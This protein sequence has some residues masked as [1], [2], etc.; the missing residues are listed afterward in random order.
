MA[1]WWGRK[2]PIAVGCVFMVIGGLLGAFSNGYGS[3]LPKSP[4][5]YIR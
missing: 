2:L 5:C 3:E 1:D 4:S